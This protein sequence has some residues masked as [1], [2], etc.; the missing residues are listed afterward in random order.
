MEPIGSDFRVCMSFFRVR[1]FSEVVGNLVGKIRLRWEGGGRG[2]KVAS[3]GAGMV[4]EGGG[5]MGAFVLVCGCDEK[6]GLSD[7]CCS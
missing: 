4:R 6:R 1:S 3:A 5:G 2:R 7:H